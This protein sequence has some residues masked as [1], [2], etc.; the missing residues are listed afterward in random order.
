M[1]LLYESFG[2]RRVELMA[3]VWPDIDAFVSGDFSRLF[4]AIN[5]DEIFTS[6]DIRPGRGVRFEGEHWVYDLNSSSLL[7]RCSGYADPAVMRGR[8]T[9]LLEKTRRYFA[10]RQSLAFYTDHVRVYGDVP[11]D[12][13][14]H[15]GKVVQKRLLSRMKPEDHQG[16]PGLQGAGLRLVGD[17]EDY[18]WHAGLE[19][20]HGAY[21]ESLSLWAELMFWP[22]PQPPSAGSD[23]EKIAQN[24][25]SAYAFVNDV[26]PAFSAKLFK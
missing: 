15:V 26:L 2:V 18:H 14:R 23:L 19:P 16:L 8:F 1:T 13:G 17:H 20:P 6:S 5:D 11:E 22:D 4:G 12:K 7:I 25:N 10:E 21:D 9:S 3:N 24:L